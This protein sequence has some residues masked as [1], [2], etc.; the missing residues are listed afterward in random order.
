[1]NAAYTAPIEVPMTIYHAAELKEFM[2][3]ALKRGVCVHFDLCAVPEI[4]CAGVQLLV[5]ARRLAA[6]R[7]QVCEFFGASD[8]VLATLALL[9]VPSTLAQAQPSTQTLSVLQEHA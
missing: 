4:D 5:A 2:L 9:G 3:E 1:M 7:Q 8:A 6:E